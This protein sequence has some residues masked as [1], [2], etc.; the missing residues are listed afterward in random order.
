MSA[1]KLDWSFLARNL[2]RHLASVDDVEAI[3][4]IMEDAERDARA[5]GA[6]PDFWMWVVD[7]YRSAERRI[8]PA[9]GNALDELCRRQ[10]HRPIFANDS[11]RR[12]RR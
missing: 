12:S 2:A 11:Y 4:R 8:G 7:E 5:L 3:E 10:P 9:G 1:M 6:P